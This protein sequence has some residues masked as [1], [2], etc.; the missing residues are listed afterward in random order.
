MLEKVLRR[1]VVREDGPARNCQRRPVTAGGEWVAGAIAQ[2]ER[3]GTQPPRAPTAP[4]ERPPADLPE[5]LLAAR[6][7]LLFERAPGAG[8]IDVSHALAAQ[9][10]ALG[11]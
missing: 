5:E 2:V 1:G 9:A 8:E 3:R 7:C 10:T 6:G 4:L 11:N